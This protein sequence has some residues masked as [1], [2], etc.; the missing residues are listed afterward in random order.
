MTKLSR[1]TNDSMLL[2]LEKALSQVPTSSPPSLS[3]KES[4]YPIKKESL[5][6]YRR[7]RR[8]MPLCRS[9]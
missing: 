9:Y 6:I 4:K 3:E 5:R 1:R 2:A 7:S 8:L